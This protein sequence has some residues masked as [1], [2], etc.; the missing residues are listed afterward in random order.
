[1][2]RW[3]GFAADAVANRPLS[4]LLTA[5]SAAIIE[6]GVA[7]VREAHEASIAVDPDPVFVLEGDFRFLNGSSACTVSLV[8]LCRN[9]RIVE[10]IVV[11]FTPQENS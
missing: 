8:P 7:A 3:T 2:V 9:P 6:D 5:E 4:L 1:M 10:S 11:L